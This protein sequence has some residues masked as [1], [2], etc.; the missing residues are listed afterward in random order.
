MT[1]SSNTSVRQIA[2]H[3]PGSTRVFEQAG[4]DYCGG[5]QHTLHE[6]CLAAKVPLLEVTRKLEALAIP[7]EDDLHNWPIEPLFVL[8]SHIVTHHHEYMRR[9]LPRLAELAADVA[10]QDGPR[11][12]ELLRVETLAR[13]LAREVTLHMTKEEQILFPYIMQLE[14]HDERNEVPPPPP[15]GTVE[16]PIRMMMAEHDSATEMLREIRHLSHGFTAP[17][18]AGT[19]FLLLYAGL[20]SLEADLHLHIHLENNVLFPRALELEAK[21]QFAVLSNI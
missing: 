21:N 9:E 2:I 12:P 17:P 18:D 20:H 6:A 1:I 14:E 15:F 10:R 4:I 19:T 13:A 11:Y 5:G 16:N 3:V 7:V 8:T